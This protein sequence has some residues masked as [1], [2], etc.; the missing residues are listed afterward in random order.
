MSDWPPMDE[1]G[2]SISDTAVRAFETKLGVTLPDDY[3]AF[4]LDVNGGS[5]TTT[6]SVF[7]MRKSI[8]VLNSLHSLDEN[9][10]RFDL[11]T[12]WNS[13]KSDLPPGVLC[14]GHD[15]GGSR[16]VL[17]IDGPHRGEVW[18]LDTLNARPEDANPRVDWFD[19]RDVVKLASSFREFMNNL[20]PLSARDPGGDPGGTGER[21]W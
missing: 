1:R 11:E 2:P 16:I 10:S 13:T 21:A 18:C 14:I 8:S 15:S 17:A 7:R 4:M 12:W 19:R 9:D 3:R 20:K 6:H 5:T